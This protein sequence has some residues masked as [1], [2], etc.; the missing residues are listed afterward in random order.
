MPDLIQRLRGSKYTTSLERGI[1][2]AAA[3]DAADVIIRLREILKRIQE[4]LRDAD[5]GD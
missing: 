2:L 3:C 5:D 1:S 4:V